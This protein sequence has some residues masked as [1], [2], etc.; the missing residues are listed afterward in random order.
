MSRDEL[1][2]ARWF[3]SSRSDHQNICVEVAFLDSGSVALRDSK[4]NGRGP[5]MVFTRDEWSAFIE[6][7]K[8]GEFD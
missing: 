3:K 6:G 5:V 7:A 8:D 2:T 1:A 4:D